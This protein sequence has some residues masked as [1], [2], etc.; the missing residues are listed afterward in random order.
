MIGKLVF[1]L[2][3][4]SGATGAAVAAIV[5]SASAPAPAAA[6]AAPAPAVAA[7][8]SNDV[9][10]SPAPTASPAADA[11]PEPTATPLPVDSTGHAGQ[12]SSDFVVATIQ[13]Q[14]SEQSAG[15][16]VTV[17]CSRT[18]LF[19]SVVGDTFDCSFTSTNA[20]GVARDGQIEVDVTS[21][22]NDWTWMV[23]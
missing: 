17:T 12:I 14:L 19:A 22:A 8:S 15:A 5:I 20:A 18:G 1:P 21:T 9:S 2:I 6:T 13:S 10:P 16:T 4:V 3:A 11:S 23:R 7:A